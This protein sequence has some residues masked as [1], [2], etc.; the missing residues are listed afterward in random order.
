MYLIEDCIIDADDDGICLKSHDFN[1]IVEN[2]TV[3][4]C[5]IS[6]NCNA[7]KFGTKSDGGFRNINISNCFIKKA[8]EDNVRKWQENLEFIEL[9]TTILAG[10]ALESVDGGLIEN[11]NISDIEMYDVQ[12][13]VFVIMGRRNVGQAGNKSFY[14][15]GNNPM[16]PTL[17]V[18][19]VSNL[20]FKNIK[21]RSHSK[22]TS[23][24][25]AV[26][27][28]YIENVTLENIEISTMGHGTMEDAGITLPEYRGAYP[29]NRM[30]GFVYP[31]SGLFFRHV[32]DITL[33]NID[34]E[35]RNEDFRPAIIFEDVHNAKLN[36]LAAM[37]PVGK[38]PLIKIRESSDINITGTKT[39]YEP[40]VEY[41]K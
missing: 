24:I 34:L 38:Q 29:E 6:T 27:G 35:V 1:R 8:S 32:K 25:T 16:D 17:Q 4:N 2:V 23:S 31:S 33:N 5:T 10:F 13:P 12:T 39:D 41:V 9:P 3:R 22:M 20:S 26:P 11:V 21:A 14:S 36:S 28:Y 7:V 30:Y 40:L 18:G 19:K 37:P 15:S